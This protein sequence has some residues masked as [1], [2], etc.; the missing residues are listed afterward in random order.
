MLINKYRLL[1][2]PVVLVPLNLTDLCFWATND[3]V[4]WRFRTADDL[5]VLVCDVPNLTAI[6]Y[7]R[8]VVTN[9][10]EVKERCAVHSSLGVNDDRW[11]VIQFHH[12]HDS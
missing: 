11:T 9:G 8:E 3:Y 1:F 4:A 2:M 12:V 5:V 10:L 7:N 6:S